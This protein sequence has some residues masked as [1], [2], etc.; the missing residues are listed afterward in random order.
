MIA[1]VDFMRSD[2]KYYFGNVNRLVAQVHSKD[3]EMRERRVIEEVRFAQMVW[4]RENGWMTSSGHCWRKAK[5]G[6]SVNVSFRETP[7]AAVG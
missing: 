4:G 3:M 5:V 6:S 1:A 7:G 2:G